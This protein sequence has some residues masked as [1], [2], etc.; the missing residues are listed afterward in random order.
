MDLDRIHIVNLEIPGIIGINPDERENPQ[1]IRVN[2]TLW[3][4]IRTAAVSDDIDDAANYKTITKAMIRHIEEG[5]PL[6]VERL[7]QELA[8]VCFATEPMVQVAEVSVEKPGALRFAES[9]GIT[10]RRT[11]VDYEDAP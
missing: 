10:I 1:T 3:V 6:L 5:R 7:V 9:V 11:R 2:A 8:D 4:D